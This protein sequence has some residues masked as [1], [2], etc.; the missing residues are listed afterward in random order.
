MDSFLL[1]R[2]EPSYYA[3]IADYKKEMKDNHDEFDG[4]SSL[5]K[6]DDIEKWHLNVMLFERRETL[7]PGYSIGFEYVYLHD[8]EVVGMINVRPFALE[9]IYLKRFGGHIGYSVKP[10]WRRKGV[11]SHMLHDMLRVCKETYHLNKVLITCN[12]DNEGS[13]RVIMNN[14]GRLEGKILYPPEDKMIERYWI[15]L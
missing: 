1:S 8:D 2:I 7:P 15:S 13:R 14:G 11:G 6:Y 12:E 3:S 5:E 4:C 9:H 10:S